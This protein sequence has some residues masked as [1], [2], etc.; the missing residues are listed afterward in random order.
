MLM[1]KLR[2]IIKIY[3]LDT[4]IDNN[5]KT[6]HLVIIY[7][8]GAK[9]IAHPPQFALLLVLHQQCMY[10]DFL[11]EFLSIHQYYSTRTTFVPS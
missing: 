8:I 2:I 11:V 5:T 3:L 10:I 6:I 7:K 4:K 9:G 1:L